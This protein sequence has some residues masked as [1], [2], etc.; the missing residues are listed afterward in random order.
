M[1]LAN[2]L[3]CVCC[4][5]IVESLGNDDLSSNWSLCEQSADTF[6]DLSNT[7]FVKLR[8]HFMLDLAITCLN[9]AENA[10]TTIKPGAFDGLPE[11]KHLN[12]SMNP[13]NF[14]DFMGTSFPK[15]ET[16]VMN[17]PFSK[18]ENYQRPGD[19]NYREGNAILILPNLKKL[20][21]CQYSRSS[22]LIWLEHLITPNLT[23][24]YFSENEL[25][26]FIVPDD[27][28]SS[29]RH[30]NLDNNKIKVFLHTLPNLRSLSMN[31]NEIASL[32]NINCNYNSM[33]LRG[34]PKLEELSLMNNRLSNIYMDAFEHSGKLRILNLGNNALEYLSSNN[35]DN[36]TRLEVLKLN[37]NQLTKVPDIC[38]LRNLIELRLDHNKIISVHAMSFCDLVNL[39]VLNLNHNGLQHV[40]TVTFDGLLSLEE[41]DLSWNNLT[42]VPD[43][44]MGFYSTLHTLRLDGNLF[45]DFT[46]MSLGH[47]KKLQLLSFGQNPIK[48]ITIE[49]I[50]TLP[51][52]MKIDL[53]CSNYT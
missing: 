29:I 20:S 2:L 24:L 33:S 9:L 16:L 52:H 1:I 22:A 23:H 53:S 34:M 27:Y 13:V 30:I 36:L 25:D 6:L 3:L 46:S 31:H 51:K 7:G 45:D 10:V 37:N 21:L 14:D 15:L 11:L 18:S 44:W 49:S 4:V 17:G 39:E 50:L 26:N 35:F 5:G 32:C 41:L 48:T 12:L 28:V 40:A 42:S 38:A 47:L 43:S 19:R 8:K